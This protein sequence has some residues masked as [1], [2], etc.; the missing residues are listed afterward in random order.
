MPWRSGADSENEKNGIPDEH[1]R[2]SVFS[3]LNLGKGILAQATDGAYP[4]FRYI[5]PGSA[6]CDT[7]I[8]IALGGIVHITARAFVLIHND[9]SFAQMVINKPETQ[10]L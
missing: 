10:A 1:V 3:L 8:G 4:I 5:F 2:D 7:A 9:I 6:R